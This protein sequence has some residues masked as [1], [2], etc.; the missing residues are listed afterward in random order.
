MNYAA[1]ALCLLLLVLVST[2]PLS[3]QIQAGQITGDITDP[4]GAA[5]PNAAVT[6]KNPAT[7]LSV[8]AATNA[9]GHFVASQL[10]VGQ[11]TVSVSAPG[12]KTTTRTGVPVN[13][14]S[15]SHFDF[16]LAVGQVSETVEVSGAAP[17]IDVESSRLAQTVTSEQVANLPLNG[18]NVYDLI[19]MVPPIFP[20]PDIL[21]SVTG[22]LEILGA[23]GLL[24]PNTARGACICLALLL[25][26]V[27]PANIHAAR[28]QGSIAG[29][30]VL[31]WPVRGLIQ[32]V[33]LGTLAAAAWLR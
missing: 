12:F 23:I 27:F 6:V 1:K 18:R 9:T 8:N 19:K 29:R 33:F 7:G 11:Y 15:I 21:V 28:Q 25:I 14:G 20:R 22:V 26:V 31:N 3:A 10:P 5:I 13:A 16:K 24:V 30:R 32:L 4:K 2:L 17:Q